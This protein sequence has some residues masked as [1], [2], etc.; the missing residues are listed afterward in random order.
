MVLQIPIYIGFRRQKYKKH[1]TTRQWFSLVTKLL[2]YKGALT[3]ALFVCKSM[4]KIS[5][6]CTQFGQGNAV[7]VGNSA[8]CCKPV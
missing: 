1:Q 3:I 2:R 5:Y 6:F 8:R 7:K 4:K